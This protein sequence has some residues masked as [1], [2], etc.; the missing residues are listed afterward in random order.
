[1]Y[2]S[3][4]AVDDVIN[5]LAAFLAPFVPGGQVVRSQTNRVALPSNPCCVLTEILMVDLSV[6][7]TR[8]QGSAGTAQI[9]GP[10]RID[11]QMDFYGVQAGEFCKTAKTALR[12]Q[13]GFNAFPANIRPLYTSDAV[14][15]PL[16]TGEQQYVSRWTATAHIQYNPTVTVP[17]DSATTLGPVGI[18]AADML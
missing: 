7:F 10:S 14:Q 9:Y 13:W 1:M 2:T 18:V 4:I 5:A 12:S 8:Y 6:P 11:I 15:A 3:D 17:Q 16:T